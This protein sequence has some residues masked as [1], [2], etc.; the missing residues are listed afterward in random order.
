MAGAAPG[1]GM[2]RAAGRGVPATPGSSGAAPGLQ[3]PVRGVGGPSQQ[4]MTP[5]GRGASV[6]APPQP[7]PGQMGGPPR[8]QGQFFSISKEK[9]FFFSLFSF[10]LLS[11]NFLF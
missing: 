7:R 10:F 6:S 4:M 2:G 8:M 5:Q 11:F 9:N 1:H 3:G